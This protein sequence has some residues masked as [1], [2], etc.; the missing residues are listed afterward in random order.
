MSAFFR[1]ANRSATKALPVMAAAALTSFALSSYQ[2]LSN[3]EATAKKKE[4]ESSSSS[5]SST[6]TVDSTSPKTGTGNAGFQRDAKGY[7]YDIIPNSQIFQPKLEWPM[8]DENWDGREPIP[9]GNDKLDRRK[10]RYLRKYGVTRH[11]ILVR[12]GQYDETHKEDEKRILTEL[13]RK[14]ANETGKRLAQMIRGAEGDPDSP[15][16]I[17]IVRVSGM[18]RAKE[19][20]DIIASHFPQVERAEPDPLLNEGRPSHH[21]PSGGKV[22]DNTIHKTQE[23]HAR[24]EEA[25]Q[26]NF[27]RADPIAMP[28][29]ALF[30]END[31]KD[32]PPPEDTSPAARHEY[33][34]IVCHAN[35]IRYFC[36]RALQLPPEAWLRLCT[37]N[38]SLTY[39]TI[40]PTGGVSCRTL[41]DVGHLSP[42]LVTFSG[43]HGF[44]W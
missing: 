12:H 20:C 43:H 41:G 31:G 10:R 14:Q 26:K 27:H 36:L 25:F 2:G 32:V 38:C 23:Q 9:S 42:E 8:Y 22:S 39:L 3:C 21:I 13:G 35:V 15:C 6:S 40:R 29:D 7:F 17:K 11:I 1:F 18:A 24:I 28:D 5:S 33:E 16:N 44:N 4:N 19:T 30:L 37:F 34:I